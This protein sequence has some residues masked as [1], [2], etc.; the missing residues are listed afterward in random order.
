MNCADDPGRPSARYIMEAVDKVADQLPHFGPAI[1]GDT[2][3]AGV[4]ESLDPLHVGRADLVT[5]ALVIAMAG[6]PATPIAWGPGLVNSIGDAV[7][8]SSDGDGHGAFL[9]NSDCVTEVV[10]DYLLELI[11]PEDGWSC[12]E[13]K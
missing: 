1:R 5:P 8:I 12:K 10:F 7:L 9:T 3:C 13:P 4:E 6:D 11:V 2:G